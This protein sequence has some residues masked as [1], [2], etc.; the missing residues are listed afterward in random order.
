[1]VQIVSNSV[2]NTLT[3]TTFAITKPVRKFVIKIGMEQ[4]VQFT[5][6]N[7]TIPVG[8]IFV[9][10]MMVEKFVIQIGMVQIAQH[11]ANQRMIPQGITIVILR[12]VLKSVI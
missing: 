3:V 1:M 4:S 9:A 6:G 8:T 5:V 10:G 11:I 2:V 12:M 7:K